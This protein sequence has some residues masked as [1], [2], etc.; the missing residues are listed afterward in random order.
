MELSLKEVS[1][2]KVEDVGTTTQEQVEIASLN[3]NTNSDSE[4]NQWAEDVENRVMEW[5]DS[6]VG[7]VGFLSKN[8]NGMNFG[9]SGDNQIN[10]HFGYSNG[11][12]VLAENVNSKILNL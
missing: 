3:N 11:D 10:F 2:Y 9:A 6:G 5:R 7:D 8:N 1:D 4:I 12:E